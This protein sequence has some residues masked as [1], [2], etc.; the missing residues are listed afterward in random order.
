MQFITFFTKR[1]S[2]GLWQIDK[3]KEE[4]LEKTYKI[5]PAIGQGEI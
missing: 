2:K 1:Q 4:D 5:P 3:K